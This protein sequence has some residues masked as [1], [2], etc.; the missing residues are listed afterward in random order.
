MAGLLAP[1]CWE[2]QMWEQLCLLLGFLCSC[3]VI[4]LRALRGGMLMR[5]REDPLRRDRVMGQEEP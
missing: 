3:N 2:E 4:P 1:T 5:D